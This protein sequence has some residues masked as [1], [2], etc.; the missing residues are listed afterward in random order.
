MGAGFINN[1]VLVSS[2]QQSELVIYIF[3]FFF[4]I[5]AL[6]AF[7]LSLLVLDGESIYSLTTKPILLLLARIILVN[8]RHK[9]TAIQVKKEKEPG[10]SDPGVA[11]VLISIRLWV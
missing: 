7:L 9:L 8:I 2:I 1:V 11:F 3:F 10:D 4:Q 6:D 5:K